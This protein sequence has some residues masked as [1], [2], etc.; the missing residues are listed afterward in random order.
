MNEIVIY[1]PT[2]FLIILIVFYV[3]MWVGYIPTLRKR[4]KCKHCDGTGWVDK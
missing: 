2:L 1:I 4:T 3:G